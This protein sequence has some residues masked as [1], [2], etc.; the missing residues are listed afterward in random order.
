MIEQCEAGDCGLPLPTDLL[1]MAYL[2]RNFATMEAGIMI[3][4]PK[5][6]IFEFWSASYVLCE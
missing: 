2:G 3:I 6:I 5:V 4:M 1:C